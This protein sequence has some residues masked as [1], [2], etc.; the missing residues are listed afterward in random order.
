[1][2]S[3]K[4][5][6]TLSTWVQLISSMCLFVFLQNSFRCKPFVTHCTQIRSWLVI[7][8]MLSDI[9]TISF[10]L[11]LKWTFTC[12]VCSRHDIILSKPHWKYYNDILKD[13]MRITPGLKLS[14]KHK[15]KLY[16]KWLTNKRMNDEINYK[17]YRKFSTQIA[18]EAE[19]TYFK[20]LFD[21][22]TNTTKQL[23]NNLHRVCLFSKKRIKYQYQSCL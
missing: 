12:T 23:W 16:K 11:H 15:N 5:F 9:I 14:S 19:Q 21:N 10:N 4:T 8:W 20:Q 3:S 17:N 6:L 2:L 1:M 18:A 22:R 13:K 7:M